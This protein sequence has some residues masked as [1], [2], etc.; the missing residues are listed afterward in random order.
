MSQ[1]VM[2]MMNKHMSAYYAAYVLS[3]EDVKH[4]RKSPCAPDYP[5]CFDMCAEMRIV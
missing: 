3:K 5:L 1:D 2:K 4:I